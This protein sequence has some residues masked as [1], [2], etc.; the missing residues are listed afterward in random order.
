M[1]SRRVLQV[2]LLLLRELRYNTVVKEVESCDH[3]R[4]D[5]PRENVGRRD[6]SHV[7]Y[8]TKNRSQRGLDNESIKKIFLK[9]CRVAFCVP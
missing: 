5:E 9:M 8:T 2:E 3:Q 1:I 7:L 6:F 4:G